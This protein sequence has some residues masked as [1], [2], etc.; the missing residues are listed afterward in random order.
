MSSAYRPSP[1]TVPSSTRSRP[2]SGTSS[3]LTRTRPLSATVAINRRPSSAH[4][5]KQAAAAS[6]SSTSSSSHPLAYTAASSH[7]LN[8]AASST[9]MMSS[10]R[11]QRLESMEEYETHLRAEHMQNHMNRS[12]EEKEAI[13]EALAAEQNV[14][15]TNEYIFEWKRNSYGCDRVA[16]SYSV[17]YYIFLSALLFQ[18]CLCAFARVI[19]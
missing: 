1:S 6:S 5:K 7:P 13:V 11:R 12:K 4:Y 17:L 9:A 14:S 8:H 10:N 16:D 3:S 18:L 2:S 15:Q 19:F